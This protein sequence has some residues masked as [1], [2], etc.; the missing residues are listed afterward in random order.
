MDGRTLRRAWVR[1]R[2]H[3]QS[4][5]SGPRFVFHH[6]PK[7]GGVSV[8]R[9]LADWFYRIPDYRYRVDPTDFESERVTPDPVDVAGMRAWDCLVGHLDEPGIYLH[10]RYPEVLRNRDFFLF[11]FVRHP[12]Q[13]QLSLYS[14]E[15]KKGKDFG[16]HELQ[17][18]LLKRPNYL[19]ERMPCDE[20]DW[21]SVVRRYQFIGTTGDLQRSFDRLAL[22][23]NLVQVQMPHLNQS[24]SGRELPQFE[25]GFLDAFEKANSVDYAIYRYAL[26]EWGGEP[27]A[28]TPEP[29]EL[30]PAES[31]GT[32]GNG[33]PPLALPGSDL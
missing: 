3:L 15:K 19:A 4:E 11:T 23:L 6:L 32:P 33:R 5:G 22:C 16:L 8:R 17:E 25:D 30:V 10:E 27:W 20:S 26:E 21:E 7:T 1:L 9:A 24:R 29:G 14:W 28:A 18:E 2:H 12:L 31:A 13:L